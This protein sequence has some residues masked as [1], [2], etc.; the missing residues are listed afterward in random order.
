M[1]ASIKEVA[2]LAGV[3]VATVSNVLNKTKNV[4]PETEKRVMDAVQKL[5]YQ[6]NPLARNLRRGESKIVG[7]IVSD[8]SNY[9]FLDLA[10][11]ME[12]GLREEGYH[13]L[14]M[15]SKEDKMLEIENIKHLL[16]RFVD[17]FIIAP[18]DEDCS[19]LHNLIRTDIP[20]VF[21]DRNPSN[22][23]G[24][25]VLSTNFKGAYDGVKHLINEGHHKIA[26]LG[27]RFDS[28]M[29]ERI[30][31]YKQALI[32]NGIPVNESFIRY[33]HGYSISA[34]NQRHGY[35]YYQME[36]LLENTD[37]TSVLLGNN[38]S[39]IGA[40]TYLREKAVSIPDRVAVLTYDDSYWLTMTTPAISA[41]AQAPEKMGQEAA[42]LLLK[43]LR[44][45]GVNELP[46]VHERIPTE[47]I[48]RESV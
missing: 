33:G 16:S 23:D 48:I 35:S 25:V 4:R 9:Y 12:A 11:G 21:V 45:I 15:D 24:D 46:Y 30:S 40:I 41:I 26:F 39:S 36:D 22:Y 17:G 5:D 6:I 44:G 31:G 2:R 27:S 19:M 43:R 13:F 10:R 32:D 38:I 3:S 20:I 1:Q 8:L 37:I 34:A 29:G 42:D 14:I 18:T 7:Y 28:T 47:L